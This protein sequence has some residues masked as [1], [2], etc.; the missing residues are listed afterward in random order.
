[1]AAAEARGPLGLRLDTLLR[2]LH[3]LQYLRPIQIIGRVRLGLLHP[4]PDLRPAPA[5]RPMIG[6]YQLPIE[7]IPALIAAER[8][9]F[10]NVEGVCAA[11]SDWEPQGA[12]KLWI[13]NLHYFDDLSAS[14][15]HTRR[16]W[17]RRLLERWVAENPPGVGIAWEPFPLSRRIVN[18]VK[19][20]LR[21]GE[22]P[23]LCQTSLAVQARWLGGRLEYHLLGNHLLAN[24][25]ALIHAGLYFA[26]PEAERW[27]T[28]GMS[29]MGRELHE[30]VLSDGGHFERSPMYHALVLEDLLDVINLLRANSRTPPQDWFATVT[31]MRRWLKV[32]THPDGEIAF[33]NDAALGVAPSSAA[34][35]AFAGRLGLDVVRD[36]TDAVVTLEPSGYVRARLGP[37]RLLCD[38]APVGPDHQP[39]HA[40]ADTLSFELSLAGRRLFVNSGTSHYG[41]DM[42][43]QRQRGTAAHNTVVVDEQDSS[44]VWAAFR[45]ARR[46]RAQLQTVQATP[47]EALIAGSHDGYGRLPGR[48]QHSRQWRLDERSLTIADQLSGAFDSAAAHFHLHPEVA[49][50][51]VS[52]GVV[53][54]VPATGGRA[55]MTFEGAATVT[56]SPSHWHPEFGLA[57][58]NSRIMARF[59][60]NA[61]TT[62]VVWT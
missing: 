8:F 61:I 40:H 57:V 31:A 5:R 20:S 24:A 2:Y 47:H 50:R 45:V 33:F 30:Q 9:R 29:L 25:K 38:C 51:L 59:A 39:G 11:A 60:G 18:W 54:L 44:E 53:E 62:R 41:S 13:Y 56:V 1:M 3:T 7:G 55:R 4:K 26:G 23:A 49:V 17:H 6:M 37:A 34:L 43:R 35:E 10:L 46:A 42:E 12:D 14:D 21:G 22:L 15:A 27:Y 36:P 58:P 32:M 16:A 28:Q 52:A 48:N 19:W